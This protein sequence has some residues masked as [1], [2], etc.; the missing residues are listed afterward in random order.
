MITFGTHPGMGIAVTRACR[1]PPNADDAQ[2]TALDR[3]CATW[4]SRRASAA[5][6]ADRRRF[7]GSCTNARISDRHA[8]AWVMADRKVAGGQA[9]IVPGR[10]RSRARRGRGARPRFRDA[11]PVA[12]PAA[13]VASR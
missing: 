5:R 11:A 13:D 4:A 10:G 3:R 1:R 6:P 2:R 7:I 12:R 9:L 8:P